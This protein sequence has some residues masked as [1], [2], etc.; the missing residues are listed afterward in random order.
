MGLNREWIP[1]GSNCPICKHETEMSYKQGDDGHEY[2]TGERCTK[3]R[4]VV[5][6]EEEK[7]K[8]KRY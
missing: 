8:A 1:S 6:F 3:C 5:N 7:I 2:E 4:W